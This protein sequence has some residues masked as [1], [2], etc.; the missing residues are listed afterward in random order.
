MDSL[1]CERTT[2]KPRKW[3]SRRLWRKSRTSALFFA[4]VAPTRRLVG[5]DRDPGRIAHA[6][7]SADRLALK[8]VEYHA[9]DA[10]LWNNEEAFDAIY[11]LDLVHHLPREQVR[12][13][14][15]RVRALLRPG[16][17]LLLKEVEDR[18]RWKMAFTW[19]L[20]RLMVGAEPI[21]YWPA[22]D[23]VALLDGLGF[24]VVKHRMRDILPY[25][26]VLYVCRLPGPR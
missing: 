5:V 15:I 9:K 2:S 20:D 4:S 10:L 21:H 22:P 23:L 1:R 12:G 11:M 18:P 16:G 8:N 7:T 17:L 13:F 25:P 14:L 6:R 3:P 19:L 24:D 26:H